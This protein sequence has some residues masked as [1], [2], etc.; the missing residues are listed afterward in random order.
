MAE[1]EQVPGGSGGNLATWPE[2]TGSPLNG[3]L[4]S[5]RPGRCLDETGF[6]SPGT[7]MAAQPAIEPTPAV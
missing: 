4:V 5:P 3:A 7:Q 1:P 6:G 2:T